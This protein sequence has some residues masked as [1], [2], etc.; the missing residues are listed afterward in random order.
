VVNPKSGREATAAFQ[1]GQGDV[2]ISYENEA[3]FLDRQNATVPASQRI[4]YV[5]PSRTFKI[6]NPVAVVNTS[7]VRPQAD[8]FVAFLF[9]TEG[10][11]LWAEAGFRPVVPDVVAA[12]AN[13]FPGEID[14]L[15]TIADLGGVVGKGAGTGGADLSR[16]RPGPPRSAVRP[17][18]RRLAIPV[19]QGSASAS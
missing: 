5:T 16:E 8:Q 15:D 6:E 17:A 13:L 19:A 18:R 11:Q 3:I 9:S 14:T 1:Q 4:E 2:L 7:E 12:T 10:Q